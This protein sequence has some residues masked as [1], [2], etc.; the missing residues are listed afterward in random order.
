[1]LHRKPK[2]L[3]VRLVAALVAGGA[4]VLAAFALAAPGDV[5][6]TVN[7][8]VSPDKLPEDERK[9]A[10]LQ[11][12]ASGCY[13]GSGNT[14]GRCRGEAP[15][16]PDPSRVVF[17]FDRKDI[18]FNPDAAKEC[19]TGANQIADRTPEQAEADCGRRSVIGTGFMIANRGQSIETADVTVINGKTQGGNPT[20]LLHAYFPAFGAGTV[21]VGV[22]KRGNKIDV[23]INPLPGNSSVSTLGADI[24]TAKGKYV[25]ARCTRGKKIETTSRWTY[26]SD[27]GVTVN[28]EQPCQQKK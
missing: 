2:R 25:Q 21:P 27:P 3:R 1:V 28:V 4:L 17:G 7:V 8:A 15:Q 24:N 6:Q 12:I 26:R 10:E 13:E 16:V 22:L 5:I 18:A 14:A 9:N 20:I 11:I 23:E 19:K